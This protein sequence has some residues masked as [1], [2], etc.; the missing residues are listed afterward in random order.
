MYAITNIAVT[1]LNAYPNTSNTNSHESFPRKHISFERKF[2]NLIIATKLLKRKI[3]DSQYSEAATESHIGIPSFLL[4][5]LKNT[6][7]RVHF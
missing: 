3:R 5:S 7:E 4:K 2:G 6:H 1:N